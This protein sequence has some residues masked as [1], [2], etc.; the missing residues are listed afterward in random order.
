M[1]ILNKPIYIGQ[2]SIWVKK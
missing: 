1:P 2:M